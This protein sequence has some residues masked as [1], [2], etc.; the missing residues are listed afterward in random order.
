ML[1]LLGAALAGAGQVAALHSVREGVGFSSLL[2]GSSS[3]SFF[4]LFCFLLLFGFFLVHLWL[5]YIHSTTSDR[6][7]R[8]DTYL[9]VILV[10]V[11][12]HVGNWDT[13]ASKTGVSIRNMCALRY[14]WTFRELLSTSLWLVSV[15]RLWPAPRFN[16]L[17]TLNNHKQYKTTITIAKVTN[18]VE[19]WQ[20][21]RSF[22]FQAFLPSLGRWLDHHLDILSSK[23]LPGSRT[24]WLPGIN[25]HSLLPLPHTNNPG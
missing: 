7:G 15:G 18:M 9:G 5:L 24:P 25:P 17:T 2:G 1:G 3:C 19:R 12:P 11:A 21:L 10:E 4:F 23:T 22:L 13:T 8:V 16:I 14:R 6:L 20:Q